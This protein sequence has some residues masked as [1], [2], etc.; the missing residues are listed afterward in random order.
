MLTNRL[1]MAIARFR[2]PTLELDF[3]AAQVGDY[4]G[5]GVYAGTITYA[6]AREFHIVAANA[7]GE[8]SGEWGPHTVLIGA[9][10][11][12]DGVANQDAV[13]AYVEDAATEARAF[14]NCRDYTGGGQDDWY[15]PAR[16]EL[17]LLYN[18]LLNHA[19][20]ADNKSSK[21]WTFSSTE[22]STSDAY[23]RSF[24]NGGDTPHDKDNITRLSRP[25]RRVPV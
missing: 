2:R 3:S 16:N 10:D 9:T 19:E 5:G 11:P 8:G 25:I 21:Q 15:L 18:N 24:Y 23:I 7:D 1:G 12:D 6:D 17:T 20:F 22:Y 14:A 4:I 13:L